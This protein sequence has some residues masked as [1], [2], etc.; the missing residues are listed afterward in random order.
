M[1]SLH[2]DFPTPPPR[3]T[4]E[5]KQCHSPPR[6]TTATP[7]LAHCNRIGVR[8]ASLLFSLRS[9]LAWFLRTRRGAGRSHGAPPPGV[10]ESANQRQMNSGNWTPLHT[11]LFL[12]LWA[13]R[14]T[15][16]L[17]MAFTTAKPPG[18]QSHLEKKRT[19]SS[20]HR[21]RIPKLPAPGHN[22]PPVN[23]RRVWGCEQAHPESGV[24]KINLKT[25]L[26]FLLSPTFAIRSR[27]DSKQAISPRHKVYFYSSTFSVCVFNSDVIKELLET[28][29]HQP[30][31][32]KKGG[33]EQQEETGA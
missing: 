10:A 27:A 17:L 13:G 33:G 24:T 8:G 15:V 30:H 22:P 23:G 29:S 32:V 18:Q 11:C 2:P 31:V 28:A 25:G 4:W 5:K 21:L 19:E 12:L 14:Q 20:A 1:C 16:I 9:P 7:S 3:T 26:D 6:R